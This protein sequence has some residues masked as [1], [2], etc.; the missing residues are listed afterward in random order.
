MER[1][2]V[3]WISEL[4]NIGKYGHPHR[5]KPEDEVFMFVK[6]VVDE[7][8][9]VVSNDHSQMTPN[10]R[11]NWSMNHELD[12]W[13]P[14]LDVAIEFQGTYWH[15]PLHFSKTAYNDEEKRIQCE[16]KGITLVQ[17]NEIDWKNN[18]EQ[19]E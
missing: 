4:I 19:V 7:G 10:D 9:D 8:I 14:S 2:G 17:V 1:Y 15:D 3:K 18:K 13:V 11:N 12:I 6:D 5:S 16:E